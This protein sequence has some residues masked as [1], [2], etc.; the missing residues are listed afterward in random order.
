MCVQDFRLFS[1]KQNNTLL[2]IQKAQTNVLPKIHLFQKRTLSV[3]F[4]GFVLLWCLISAQ[5]VCHRDVSHFWEVTSSS[6]PLF[7]MTAILVILRL[8]QRLSNWLKNVW[9]LHLEGITPVQLGLFA[10]ALLWKAESFSLNSL[11]KDVPY[12]MNFPM[13]FFLVLCMWMQLLFKPKLTAC[14]WLLLALFLQKL[15]NTGF[16]THSLQE[17]FRCIR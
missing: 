7:P 14:V 3:S 16:L 15:R 1:W 5:F 10:F 6:S 2:F 17:L 11:H 4:W 9:C 13:I 8:L 12:F